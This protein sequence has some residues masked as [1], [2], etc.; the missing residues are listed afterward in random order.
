MD[1]FK[2]L[3]DLVGVAALFG[4]VGVVMLAVGFVVVDVLTPGNL[5]SQIWDDGNL[6]ASVVVGS[7]LLGFGIIVVAS[8]RAAAD[9]WAVGLLDTA[10]YSALGIAL[11]AVTFLIID[12]L[13]PGRLGETLM[14]EKF[15]PAVIVTA[16]SNFVISVIIAAAIF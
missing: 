10:V 4:L 8:I 15:H 12:V 11:F 2:D 9:D 6:N 16:V 3:V 1:H 7:A 13:T 5:R 14:S